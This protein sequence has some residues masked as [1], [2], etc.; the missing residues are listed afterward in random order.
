MESPNADEPVPLGVISVSRRTDI[1]AWYSG[2]FMDKVDKGYCHVANP[3]NGKVEIVSLAREDVD[4]MVF[5][6]RN[7]KPA[8]PHLRRLSDMGYRFYFQFTIVGYPRF[9]DSY[10][11]SAQSACR[12]AHDLNSAFGDRSVV[13][14]YDPIMLTSITHEKWH[15]TNFERLCRLLEGATDQCIISFVDYYRKLDRNLFPLLE[16][17]GVKYFKP[18]RKT[19]DELAEKLWLTASRYGIKVTACCEPEL[20]SSRVTSS[21][22]IDPGRLQ[23]ITGKELDGAVTRP[24]RKGCL[25]AASKD[26]GAY[27]TCLARCA[28]CYAN[29]SHAKNV[30]NYRA[31][32]V[33]S[34]CLSSWAKTPGL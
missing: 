10:I 3:F 18:E 13:W 25:C 24:T 15:V 6:S 9:I 12:T 19:L 27:D 5:W 2:W 28:Y 29:R 4:A 14:R 33:S 22:C 7:Y 31:I 16:D 20:N 1:P 17:R 34:P 8:L 23:D 30:E 26:I 21:S 11:P 32:P